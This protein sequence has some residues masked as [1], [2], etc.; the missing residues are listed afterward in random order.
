MEQ[1]KN[2]VSISEEGKL[3]IHTD[4]ATLIDGNVT[5]EICNKTFEISGIDLMKIQAMLREKKVSCITFKDFLNQYSYIFIGENAD[6]KEIVK[7]CTELETRIQE[8]NNSRHWW[9]R[10]M[11]L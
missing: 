5:T 1:S 10:K 3:V 11:E 4:N 9:E 7:R 2:K 8:F 6:N